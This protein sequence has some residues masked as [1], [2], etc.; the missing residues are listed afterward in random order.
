MDANNA[1]HT[2][3]LHVFLINCSHSRTGLSLF[4]LKDALRALI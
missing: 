1:V 4:S 3:M 2:V